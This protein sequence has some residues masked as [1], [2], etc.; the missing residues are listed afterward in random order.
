MLFALL[1]FSLASQFSL[2]EQVH[3]ALNGPGGMTIAW[4]TMDNTVSSIVQVRSAK[5]AVFREYFFDPFA[6]HSLG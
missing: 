4:F 2:P 6:L 1:Q 5:I 3:I